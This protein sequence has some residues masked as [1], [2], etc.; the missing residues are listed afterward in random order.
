MEPELALL[1][2]PDL[3]QLADAADASVVRELDFYAWYAARLAEQA[4][5]GPGED[6]DAR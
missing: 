5:P 3:E 6:R 1:A 2:H 4:S